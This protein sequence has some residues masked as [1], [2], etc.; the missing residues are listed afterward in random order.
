MKRHVQTA[1]T[2]ERHPV[3]NAAAAVAG[4]AQGLREGLGEQH[5]VEESQ[6][7]VHNVGELTRAATGEARRQWQSPEVEELRRD[8]SQAAEA[9]GRRVREAR[10][11]AAPV[12][13]QRTQ[14][15][16]H[17]VQETA[18][19]VQERVQHGVEEG[20]ERTQAVG[21]T[22]RRAARA[23]KHIKDDLKEAT[24]SYAHSLTAGW[25]MFAG[26][27]VLGAASLVVLTVGLVVWLNALLG[28]PAG[29]F[30]TVLGYLVVAGVLAAVARSR[31]KDHREDAREHVQDVRRE[32][33][34]VAR[35]VRRAFS[36][37]NR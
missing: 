35:P 13:Q 31:R 27:G 5:L 16:V 20:R 15:A 10:A 18:H 14:E 1:E 24:S 9:A 3:R 22:A 25:G 6:R 12:V 17:R 34:H 28:S 2:Q 21:E 11:E 4:A 32:V 26:A 23:P 30:L 36:N 29:Y 33:R 7:A 8:T 37:H 19:G